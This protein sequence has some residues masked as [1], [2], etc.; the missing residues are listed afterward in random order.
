[1]RY[2]VIDS[3]STSDCLYNYYVYDM[4]EHKIMPLTGTNSRNKALEIRNCYNDIESDKLFY[5]SQWVE[6]VVEVWKENAR[7]ASS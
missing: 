5:A 7:V 1:M 4:I 2:E 6:K 3:G